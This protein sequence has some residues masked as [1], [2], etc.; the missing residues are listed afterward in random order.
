MKRLRT[1]VLLWFCLLTHA[2]LWSQGYSQPD[3]GQYDFSSAYF[4][5]LR[6]G[7]GGTVNNLYATTERA[8]GAFVGNELR[9]VSQPVYYDGVEG[10]Q[11]FFIR[12]WGDADDPAVVTFRLYDSTN[13][14]SDFYTIDM[15]TP[16]TTVAIDLKNLVTPKGRIMS[17]SKIYKAGFS[18]NGSSA[19][20]IKDV[21][22]SMDGETPALGIEEQMVNGKSSN[23][24]SIYNLQG[25][26]QQSLQRGINIIDGKKVFVR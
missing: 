10:C 12:V 4:V 22:L 25:Q 13:N 6:N 21:F 1:Y 26:R 8:I 15:K 24:K 20:Y 9:G 3:I 14:N 19:L 5:T 7:A 2:L 23:S 18:S 16:T 11:A 17:P